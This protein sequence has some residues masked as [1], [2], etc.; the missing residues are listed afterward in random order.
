MGP[1]HP[2]PPRH[3]RRPHRGAGARGARRPLLHAPRPPRRRRADH[4]A[5]ARPRGDQP[6]LRP[7]HR[8]RHGPAEHP[9]PLD[10][11]R[12]HAGDLAAPGEPRDAHHRGVR[13]HPAGDPRLA[14]R[15][16]RRGRG[17]RPAAGDRR[18]P[19]ALHRQQGVLEPAAQVQDRDLLAAG[20]RARGQRRLLHRRRAPRARPGLRPVGRRRAVD[21]PEDRA[22]ARRLGAARRGPRRLGG[23][24]LD[25][26]GLRLPPAAA[27]RADQVPGRGLGRRE[28]PPGAGGRVPAP[29]AG[30]RARARRPRSAR[31]TTS[32]VHKQRDGLNYVG[33]A[34]AS[35][36]VSGTTLV[37]LADAAERG[38]LAAGPAHPA[39][40]D[41]RARRARTGRWTRSRPR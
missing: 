27:P 25:L 1:L 21:E 32:G 18:D 28:V 4:R 17:D 31:S 5:A 3:R 22:A 14:G 6:D 38:R 8:G 16:H 23:R 2:A 9:V 29:H 41:R 24:H 36:R 13:R 33:V 12:E 26:P 39:A 35:G 11:D 15:R 10:R 40:E 7:R 34:P 30:R 37:A 19:R 20:R